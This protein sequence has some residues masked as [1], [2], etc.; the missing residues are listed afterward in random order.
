MT[1]QAISPYGKL[2]SGRELSLLGDLCEKNGGIQTGPFGSQLHS[3]DY[4]ADGTPIVTVENLVGNAIQGDSAPMVSDED[5]ARLAKYTLRS[6]DLVFSRVGSVDRCALVAEHQSGWLFSGRLIRIRPDRQKID[7]TYLSYF[8]GMPKVKAYIRRIAVGATMPSLNTSIMENLQIVVP[9]RR[10]QIAIGELLSDIDAKIAINKRLSQNLELVAT[11]MFKSWFVDFDPVHAKA[12]GEQPEG[13]DSE[14]AALFPDS[15]EDSELGPIPFGWV[16]STIGETSNL[17]MG[18]SPP[19]ES[20]NETGDGLP[21]FQGRT[22]FGPRFPTERVYTTAGKRFAKA[23]DT[24]ISVRAPVGDA[25]QALTECVV[26]RGVAAIRHNSDSEIYTYTLLSSLRPKLEYFNGEGTVFGAINRKDFEELAVVEPS[27]ELVESFENLLGPS[28]AL[29][30]QLHDENLTLSR[31]RD[32]LLPR[33]ISG[34][35]EIPEELLGE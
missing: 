26:G 14:T 8:F 13:M 2:T 18:Q 21:F 16:V 22:D 6:G 7:P 3:S 9:Q 25:N 11:A 5:A 20:Y 10:E 32:S 29:I 27:A 24:L 19:G 12:R 30:R 28:N 1:N 33:L 15:F 34:D 17:F 35:L 4:V 23:G 31:L